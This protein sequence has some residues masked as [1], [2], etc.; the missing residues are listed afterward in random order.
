MALRAYI[1]R[2]LL[3]LYPVHAQSLPIASAVPEGIDFVTVVSFKTLISMSGI[4]AHH[5]CG[6]LNNKHNVDA[7]AKVSSDNNNLM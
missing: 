4:I 7:H 2:S 3:N 5:F 1:P 6:L